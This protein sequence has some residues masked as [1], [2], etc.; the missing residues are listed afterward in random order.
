LLPANGSI[1]FTF[2]FEQNKP[3][4]YS[5][6]SIAARQ[7]FDVAVSIFNNAF[8]PMNLAN[9]MAN[10]NYNPN[11]DSVSAF[12]LSQSVLRLEQPTSA[13]LTQY[14][15]P[16]LTNIQNQAQAFNTEIRLNIQDS[17]VPTHVGFFLALPS[18]TVDT[19]FKL[20][21]YPNP[22]VMANAQ[23]MQA[24][25][26]GTMSIMINNVQYTQ[27][28]DLWR[29]W[30][31]NQT[32]Q[33]TALGAG[34]PEDQ[35]SGAD[36]GFYPMQ[37]FILLIGSQNIVVNINLPA[38]PSGVDANSRLVLMFRGILAQNSTVVN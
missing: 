2:N 38:P 36:D 8:N 19:T 20:M 34:S 15:F 5:M 27:K 30:Q 6:N 11:F 17:F 28:W 3:K 10:P 7:D 9:G 13:N 12:R 22:F 35:Y 24:Y 18:S 31:T 25:Y 21:T 33:T 1:S 37:P 4:T 16:V 14:L 29:H 26:N 23:Q 32:Q